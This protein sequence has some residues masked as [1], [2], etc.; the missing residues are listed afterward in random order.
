[1]S[2]IAFVTQTLDPDDAV[3]GATVGMVRGLAGRFDR[4][5]VIANEVRAA[6]GDLGPNVMIRPLGKERGRGRLARGSTY[7]RSIAEIVRTRPA[8]VLAHMCPVYLNLAAP[9]AK[10]ARVPLLLWFAHPAK[11]PSL[12]VSEGLADAILTSLPGA[13]PH[14]GPKVHVIGQALD[15]SMFPFSPREDFGDGLALL[16]VGRTSPSKGFPTIL[17]AVAIARDA[18]LDVT[19][20]IVGPSTTKAERRHRLELERLIGILGLA[21]AVRLGQGAPRSRIPDVIRDCDALVNATVGGSGDKTLLE[22]MAIGRPVMVS[23]PAFSELIEALP[24]ALSFRE[25]DPE[26]LAARLLGLRSTAPELRIEAA[27]LLRRRVEEGHSL[28]HWAS[29]V[30]AIVDE[31]SRWKVG[32]WT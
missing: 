11:S 13:Y 16:A 5:W 4:V 26:G 20:R 19:L 29:S 18:G 14:P 23:N 22:A 21:E 24:L 7:L 31:L 28:E 8:A 9:I 1:M 17:R 6:C 27:R 12:R 25:G 3:L 2:G 30:A 15:L 10:P 32:G